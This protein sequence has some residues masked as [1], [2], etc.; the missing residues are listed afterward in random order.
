M[1]KKKK[2]NL[3]LFFKI[4]LIVKQIKQWNGQTNASD[5]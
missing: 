2:F 3:D 5:N 4:Q 1:E